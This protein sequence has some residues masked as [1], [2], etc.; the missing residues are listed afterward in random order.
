M[1]SQRIT[2]LLI[3]LLTAWLVTG[4][5]PA[6]DPADVAF[7]AAFKKAHADNDTEALFALYHTEGVPKP[8]LETLQRNLAFEIEDSIAEAQVV[9]LDPQAAAEAL[10]RSRPE[11][12][13]ARPNLDPLAF[14]EVHYDVP[15][16]RRSTFLLGRLSNGDWRILMFAVGPGDASNAPE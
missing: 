2:P 11:D 12:P 5:G 1:L 9:R 6:Q 3:A 10:E 8:L 14:L 4:C 15:E 13:T 16:Q 7:V